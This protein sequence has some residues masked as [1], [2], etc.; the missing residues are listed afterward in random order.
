MAAGTL[1]EELILN[2]FLIFSLKNDPPSQFF[3]QG[4]AAQVN[5]GIGSTDHGCA[6]RVEFSDGA[7]GCLD[8]NI[9]PNITGAVRSGIGHDA[10]GSTDGHAYLHFSKTDCNLAA[11]N[12]TLVTET[13]AV[14]QSLVLPDV[15]IG[16]RAGAS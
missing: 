7:L 10:A 9:F 2:H 13:I 5:I 15:R 1:A 14:K 8:V 4:I 3:V 16:C 6:Q 11:F 12:Q